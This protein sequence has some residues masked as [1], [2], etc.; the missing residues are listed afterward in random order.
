MADTALGLTSTAAR[1]DVDLVGVTDLETLAAELAW[2][3]GR[4]VDATAD[5]MTMARAQQAL[6]RWQDAASG[7]RGE[8]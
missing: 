6:E 7:P 8:P 4:F 3:L 5:E 2:C 1:L